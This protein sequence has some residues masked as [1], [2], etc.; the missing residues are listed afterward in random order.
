DDLSKRRKVL[1]A[2]RASV[3]MAPRPSFN[4]VDTDGLQRV[5]A[6]VADWVDQADNKDR[7]LAL[8]ALQVSISAT[9]GA[10]TMSGVLPTDT[11]GFITDE[12]S[13]QCLYSG[14]QIRS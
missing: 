4:D 13:S 5:C 3:Q 11:P 14:D 9:K 1:E 2:Q 12:Q 10:A 7:R 8:E 6:G